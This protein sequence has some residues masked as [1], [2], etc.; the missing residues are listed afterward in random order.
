MLRRRNMSSKLL[1]FKSSGQKKPSQRFRAR[2]LN[3]SDDY[4]TMRPAC[5]RG[6]YALQKSQRRLGEYHKPSG[7]RYSSSKR[8]SMRR[9]EPSR[10]AIRAIKPR[11][12]PSAGMPRS[13]ARRMTA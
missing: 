3:R 6:N 12:S 7:K 4:L 10:A 11:R 13:P 2:V 5:R 9:V 8:L 1:S